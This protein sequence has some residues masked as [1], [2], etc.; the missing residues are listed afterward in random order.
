MNV[1]TTHGY[2]CAYVLRQVPRRNSYAAYE[3]PLSTF[4]KFNAKL[5]AKLKDVPV[6]GHFVRTK[7]VMRGSVPDYKTS[8]Y[9][10][11]PGA[12]GIQS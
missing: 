9:G 12:C 6:K 3:P 2:E 8:H 10:I 1:L 7:S 11:S 4:G 5:C